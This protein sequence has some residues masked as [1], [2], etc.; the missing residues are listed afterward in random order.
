MHH[1][2][3]YVGM[4]KYNYSGAGLTDGLVMQVRG[5]CQVLRGME[6]I[7]SLEIGFRDDGERE[8]MEGIVLEPFLALDNVK[9]VILSGDCTASFSRKLQRGLLNAYQEARDIEQPRGI[10][11]RRDCSA[12]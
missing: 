1:V 9:A 7:G 10:F 6:E 4:V 11:F 8:G 5:L 12:S 2:D 3:S